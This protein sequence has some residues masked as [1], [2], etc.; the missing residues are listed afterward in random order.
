MLHL[1]VFRAGSYVSILNWGDNKI[2]PIFPIFPIFVKIPSQADPLSYAVKNGKVYKTSIEKDSRAGV[3]E[4]HVAG[5]FEI[6]ASKAGSG[7]VS[8][9][10]VTRAEP[11]FGFFPALVL[12]VL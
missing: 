11:V 10:D 9:Y 3:T 4:Q 2:V 7:S 6:Y 1:V 5:Q 12:A 8:G